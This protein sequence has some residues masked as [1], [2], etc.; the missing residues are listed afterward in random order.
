MPVHGIDDGNNKKAVYTTE[1]VLAILQ[2]AIDSGSLQGIDPE[3]NP[4]VA[5]VR[6]SNKN[7]NLTFWSGT[8]D[9][10]NALVGVTSELIGARIG[11]DGKL[12]LLTGDT[13]LSD[14]I[15][16]CYNA[17]LEAT[18]GMKRE[19]ISV[20]LQANG[21][22][23]NAP[24]TQTVAVPGMTADK[25]FLAPFVAPTGNESDD[26]AAQA[27]LSCISGGTTDTDSV[28]FYCYDEKPTTTIT[29]FMVDKGT[30]IESGD[31]PIASKTSAGIMKVGEGLEVDN[32]GEVSLR[33]DLEDVITNAE[34]N[35]QTVEY[36]FPKNW[37][38]TYSG[39][40][41]LIKAFGKSILIDT[42]RASNKTQLEQMLTDNGVTH[43]D[44]LIVTHYHDD[45]MGNVAN[46]VTDGFV[47]SDTKVYLTADC[48][49]IDQSSFLQNYRAE[50]INA[51]TNAEITY[52]TPAEGEMIVLGEN[53]K[54]TFY[55]T[56]RT[57]IDTY[58]DYNNASIIC[59][60]QHGAVTTMYTG[61]ALGYALQRALDNGFINQKVDLYK[62]EH[63]GI[64]H[65]NTIL[66]V[67][68]KMMP[69]YAV[70]PS[71]LGDAQRCIYS[72]STTLGY[73]QSKGCKTFS[74]HKNSDYI[75]FKS[76]PT[77]MKVVKGVQNTSISNY[78][79][80]TVNVLYAD[81]TTTNTIQDGSSQYPFKDLIQAIG[82]CERKGSGHYKVILRPGEYCAGT[83][84]DLNQVMFNCLDVEI[85]SSTD[86]AADV[87]IRGQ[88]TAQN[89]TVKF[90]K[91]TLATNELGTSSAT[92]MT[93]VRSDLELANCVLDG[94]ALTDPT[95]VWSSHSKISLDSCS[96]KNY[97]IGISAHFDSVF[98]YNTAF[99]DISLRAFQL[100][101][102][103]LRD[104]GTTYT[105]VASRF[106][107][108]SGGYRNGAIREELYFGDTKTGDITLKG[109]VR[110]FN[111]LII[112]SGYKGGGTMFSHEIY[113]WRRE[114]F[115]QNTVYPFKTNSESGTITFSNN[116]LT[117]TIAGLTTD[118]VRVI[119]GISD[120]IDPEITTTS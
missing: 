77:T 94:D 39:D 37:G 47:D 60:F 96:F 95:C 71:G 68:Q 11:S 75:V 3:K 5:A 66:K 103:D 56:D 50:V 91:V 72:A 120:D 34:G 54:L 43:I 6:E 65:N 55:N 58:S 17:A 100:S 83:A 104:N 57:A 45:H 10:F 9:E 70:Q 21:W 98:A 85:A 26:L 14:T 48:N 108:G 32:N 59:K 61:D 102:S 99:S 44:Y 41:N 28:T 12:Y 15:Q 97:R 24:Y 49:F 20:T 90:N 7:S 2:Q 112:Q 52:K 86:N 78:N 80:G 69:D 25:D 115:S 109:D 74:C 76:T 107:T 64:Q 105:N 1:E 4:I 13:T 113:S 106:S 38:L 36:I 110:R 40:A 51:L 88:V 8:E 81:A 35:L 114:N 84:N 67:L 63:H 16:A 46:L 22:S 101:A 31:L 82:E 79:S 23:S 42:H 30:K 73:L 92:T 119:W 29:V 87:I 18:E 116:G 117:G 53:C 111:R 118:G 89:S 93:I 27:A 62:I 33:S 19:V